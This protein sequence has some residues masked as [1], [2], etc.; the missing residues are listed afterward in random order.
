MEQLQT[1]NQNLG[2]LVPNISEESKDEEDQVSIFDA[3]QEAVVQI[4]STISQ[5]GK[6]SGEKSNEILNSIK[7]VRA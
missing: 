7:S 5:E 4:Q 1:I 3:L 2:H 6:I